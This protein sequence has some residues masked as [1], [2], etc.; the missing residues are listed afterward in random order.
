[1]ER[2]LPR[3]AS[4][5]ILLAFASFTSPDAV[6]I[7]SWVALS[8]TLY[9]AIVENVLR[10]QAIMGIGNAEDMEYV[11]HLSQRASWIGSVFLVMT[12][13]VLWIAY[14]GS[15][16]QEILFLTPFVAVPYISRTG[17]TAV[18]TM[19][20]AQR[21]RELARFQ[22]WAAMGGLAGSFTTVIST[23]SA[24]GMSVHVVMTEAIFATL[25]LRNAR[26]IDV[27]TDLPTREP[28]SETLSLSVL[29]GLGWSQGQLERVVIGGLAGIGT[30][31]LY[32]TASTM[33][34]SPGEALATA[35]ANYL[36]A[37]VSGLPEK[38]EHA[39]VVRRVGLLA[40]AA[41]SAAAFAAVLLVDFLFDPLLGPSWT[42]TLHAVPLL[43]VATIPYAASLG[44][45]TMSVYYQKPRASIVPALFALGCAFP[46]GWLAL[47]SL[48]AAAAM[49]IVKELMVLTLCALMA[50]L[51]GSRET[52]VAASA[53]TTVVGTIVWLIA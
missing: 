26:V 7:Y 1:M 39:A 13:I 9:L 4:A 52:V 36:R 43:A 44:L 31:G 16:A 6:G 50:R 10:N 28:R 21:W 18:A 34:R 35:T 25:A 5:A 45:Q 8:Y 17:I 2:A 15:M 29:G 46:I 49:V 14:R 19:Q 48:T 51:P 24:L 12:L 47:T 32:S 30:L 3:V 42:A 38:E 37:S 11:R 27:P 33:G 23:H 53:A 40:V 20:Y 22:L 41:A